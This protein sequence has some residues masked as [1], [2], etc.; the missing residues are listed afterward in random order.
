MSKKRR[1]E[2][3]AEEQEIMRRAEAKAAGI[4]PE[5]Y[6]SLMSKQIYDQFYGS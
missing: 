6:R 3:T 2:A 4:S 5:L 1:V